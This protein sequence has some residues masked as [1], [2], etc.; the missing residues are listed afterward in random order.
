MPQTSTEQAHPVEVISKL[1]CSLGFHVITSECGTLTKIAILKIKPMQRWTHW[2]CFFT[3]LLRMVAEN[4]V[5]DRQTDQVYTVTPAE[6][7]RWGLI[8]RIKK[9]NNTCLQTANSF[10]HFSFKLLLHSSNFL[11]VACMV[12]KVGTHSV[13]HHFSVTTY[14][15][16]MI[17]FTS[18]VLKIFANVS[19]AWR[20]NLVRMHHFHD[21]HMFLNNK[22]SHR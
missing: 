22:N 4:V 7:A 19:T 2:C 6:H 16:P 18:S 10:R 20:W 13:L 15:C 17:K 21:D 8:T 14:Y 5:T 11:T 9:H 1:A 12:I 3:C